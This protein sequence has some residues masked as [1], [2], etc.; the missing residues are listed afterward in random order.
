MSHDISRENEGKAKLLH[1]KILGLLKSHGQAVLDAFPEVENLAF[2][3]SWK[4]EMGDQLPAGGVVYRNNEPPNAQM[5]I[6]I[7]RQLGRMQDYAIRAVDRQIQQRQVLLADQEKSFNEQASK[8]QRQPATG[9]ASQEATP[10][11]GHGA[12]QPASG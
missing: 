11:T 12:V 4:P 3:I 2:A 9:E 7:S 5:L 8:A 6:R 10:A 1:E